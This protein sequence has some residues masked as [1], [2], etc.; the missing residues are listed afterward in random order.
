[1]DD[2]LVVGIGASAGGVPAL[3]ELFA[4]TS[5]HAG[6][7][8][9]AI[10]HLSPTHESNYAESLQASSPIPVQ[11]VTERVRLAAD[12]AYVVSP[13][14][15]LR[16]AD[17]FL[18][19]API[20]DGEERGAP[21]DIFF[22]TL[23]DARGAGAACVVL[24]G[25]GAD[26]ASG[27]KRVK[28]RGGL[29]LVQDPTEAPYPDMPRNA[30]ATGLVDAVLPV[31]EIPA[32]LAAYQRTLRSVATFEDERQRGAESIDDRTL[33]TVVDAEAVL[34][35]AR[36]GVARAVFPSGAAVPKPG[37][38]PT[39]GRPRPAVRE[40]ITFGDLHLRLLEQYAPPS[41][42]VNA[43]Y[44]ILHLSERAGRYLQFTDAE[45]TV[46]LMKVA[47]PEYRV[48]L[49][50]ALHEAARDRRNAVVPNV[51]V[52]VGGESVALTIHVRPV[53]REDDPGHGL[54]LV[55]FE[56]REA[57]AV[58]ATEP[59][60]QV[61]ADDPARLL[62]AEVVRLKSQLRATIERYETQSEELK[63]WNE[64]LTTVNHDLK[65]KI[66]EQA[67]ANNDSQNL[68]QATGIAA[69][70]LDRSLRIKL[71]TPPVRQLFQLSSGDSGRPLADISGRIEFSH[72]KADIE[73]VLERQERRERELVTADGQHYLLQLVP[74]RTVD[75]RIEGVVLT[76]FDVTATKK[77]E[78][79]LRASEARLRAIL[80]QATAG[81]ALA[82]LSGRLLFANERL[83][84][85]I[86]WSFDHLSQSTIQA[87]LHRVGAENA[88]ARL[89]Q[90]VA[91]GDPF[92]IESRVTTAGQQR[93]VNVALSPVRGS[94][95]VLQAIVAIALDVSQRK[96]FEHE[97]RRSEEHLR[98]VLDSITSHAVI[99]LDAGGHITNWNPGAE[100]MFGYTAQEAVGQSTGLIFTPEDLSKG[101]HLTEM[102]V[103]REKGRAA[104]ERWHM[105]KDG[106]RLYV[107]GVL[108][109]L[110]DPE[111][112]G[113]VKVA[114]DL[115]QR[116]QQEEALQHAHDLLESRVQ[117]RTGE[118]ARELRERVE[119]EGRVRKLL[120]QLITVQEEERR[121]IARDLHDDLGQKMTALHLKLE[122][123][124]RA[125]SGDPELRD[126]TK[127]AQE[128]VRALDRDLD[129]F[130]WE[131]RPAALYDLGL[132]QALRDF[133]EQW[134]THFGVE[135]HF[136]VVGVGTERYRP[137]IEINLYRIA[138]E[139][140]NN[141]HKHAAAKCVE[142]VLMRRGGELVLS[143]EDDGRGFDPLHAQQEGRGLGLTGMQERATL[144]GG[145]LQIERAASG[146]TTVMVRAPADMLKSAGTDKR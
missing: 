17:G 63:A 60:T 110:G 69:I 83:A 14:Q 45:P 106:S 33:F 76:F 95:G 43:S 109:P 36:D 9:V 28:E 112:G 129:F 52:E 71:F 138:Q 101:E 117:E 132:G 125:A 11:R 20:A 105:R 19:V 47:R 2:F 5:P 94:D 1:M 23:A 70:F 3:K 111:V 57:P 40:G 50:A 25:T 141:I 89:E 65:H 15:R 22:R 24:T 99:T 91:T 27:L 131:L 122:A 49:H 135:A 142:V 127:D 74:Y 88:V 31:C 75:G 145:T 90:L 108:S 97:L 61:G 64:E 115:T 146:G 134:S 37:L 84:S 82:D 55:L 72:I 107:S 35:Q 8:Y 143:I 92:Q 85:L 104:D 102:R 46:N 68:V 78:A 120:N 7:T 86:E 62:E 96:R 126:R 34:L 16:V 114:R 121:R 137:H 38:E 67:Q 59:V 140:L 18:E 29:C 21:I 6:I 133:V 41:L 98:Q 51:H 13:T 113:Y 144:V 56:E 42:L 80:T 130:T 32:R 48:E 12:R 30:L 79:Q 39:D 53:T 87:L 118:L 124:R 100:R 58:D 116:K 81:V 128:F 4:Q 44:D 77:A 119:A 54:F 73:A 139:A 136:E 93:W 26:G 10:L 103:A 66:E 123:L